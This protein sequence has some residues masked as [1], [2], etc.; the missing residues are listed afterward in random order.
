MFRATMVTVRQQLHRMIDDA[1]DYAAE[2]STLGKSIGDD[3]RDGKITLPI[4]H[5]YTKATP[6]EREFWERTLAS[7][8]QNE[9]DLA[10]AMEIL[11]RHRSIAYALQQAENYCQKARE[12]LNAFPPSPEKSAL[13]E[14]VGFC[15]SRAY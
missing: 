4:I 3:F 11:T 12:Q 10:H 8:E 2:Q 6:T 9:A 15:L 14:I 5:A 1:L 13:E 7:E